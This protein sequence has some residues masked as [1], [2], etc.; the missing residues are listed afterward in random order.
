MKARGE[1]REIESG[2]LILEVLVLVTTSTS[3]TS[4]T[5]IL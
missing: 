5:K 2:G 4:G 1:Q 3:T